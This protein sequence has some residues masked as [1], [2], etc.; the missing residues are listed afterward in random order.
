MPRRATTAEFIAKGRKAHGDKYDYSKVDYQGNKVPV[1][2]T[3]PDHGDFNQR[4][5]QH[6]NHGCK[7]C[8]YEKVSKS[9]LHTKEEFIED[10]L[11]IHGEHYD[12]SKVVYIGNKDPVIIGCPKHGDFPQRPND[13]LT[14]YGCPKCGTEQCHDKLRRT[15][16]EF[17]DL[18]VGAHGDRYDYSKVVYVRNDEPVIIGC[19]DHGDFPQ[20][21]T[22]HINTGGGCPACAGNLKK[23]NEIY[24]KEVI[25]KHGNRFDFSKL[26]YVSS[27]KNI[28][29]TDLISNTEITTTAVRLLAITMCPRCPSRASYGFKG[30]KPTHCSKHHL[31]GQINLVL[32]KCKTDGCMTTPSI[33]GHCSRCYYKLHPDKKSKRIKI[34]EESVIAYVEKH[35]KGYKIVYDKKVYG[36]LSLKRADIV[37]NVGTHY[38]II[39][40]DERQHKNYDPLYERMREID[41]QKDLDKPTVF[42]RFNPD[43]YTKDG[44]YNESPWSKKVG[45]C[46]LKDKDVWKYRLLKLKGLINYYIE[47]KSSKNLKRHYLYYDK[48]RVK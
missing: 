31:K 3:C 25:K 1:T 46:V 14:G 36:G 13:H 34:K 47:N 35:Y 26:E 16:S 28:T 32:P 27:M 2:I 29:V 20:K 23:T 48:P 33:E 4:P 21:P 11:K 24:M 43:S 39:E 19:P 10:A 44:V 12:Y 42:I 5:D 6:L 30:Q 8:G 40:V 15:Q 9:L 18:A 22:I 17:I 38:V 37:I 45:G 7:D 41:I